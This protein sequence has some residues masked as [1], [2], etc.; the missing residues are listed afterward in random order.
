MVIR[1]FTRVM[2]CSDARQAVWAL[3]I[4]ANLSNGAIQISTPA[5]RN[6]SEQAATLNIALMAVKIEYKKGCSAYVH[7]RVSSLTRCL[8]SR[9]WVSRSAAWAV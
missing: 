8:W 5:S 7:G 3:R 6:A 4:V 2:A 1:K 9:S